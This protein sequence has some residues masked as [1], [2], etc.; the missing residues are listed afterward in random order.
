MSRIETG[1]VAPTRNVQRA[2]LHQA[3]E[4]SD[5]PTVRRQHA[6]AEAMSR[7]DEI[8]PDTA[9]RLFADG[10][11]ALVDVRTAEERKYVGYVPGS[12]HVAWQTGTAM[13]KNPRF[14]KELS[15]KVPK[16]NVV[17]FICRSGRRSADAAVA[18]VKA[19]YAQSFNVLEGFEG[20]LD[21]NRHRGHQNGWRNRGL[22]W[23]QD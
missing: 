21:A 12:V 7:V 20:D 19:G 3:H 5:R 10:A 13:I 1:D 16:D 8:D 9:Y 14:I 4:C 6:P 15:A 22:P 11:A 18:A 17:L 23:V 2:G